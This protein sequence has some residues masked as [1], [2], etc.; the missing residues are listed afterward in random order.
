MILQSGTVGKR[1]LESVDWSPNGIVAFSVRGGEARSEERRASDLALRS[2]E[3][4]RAT[5]LKLA[6]SLPLDAPLRETFLSATRH[7]DLAARREHLPSQLGTQ[8]KPR[9]II[10]WV[11]WWEWRFTCWLRLGFGSRIGLVGFGWDGYGPTPFPFVTSA[12]LT[13]SSI[14]RPCARQI[15]S[16]LFKFHTQGMTPGGTQSQKQNK[17]CE[18]KK[19]DRSERCVHAGPPSSKKRD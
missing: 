16:R 18:E 17:P 15:F 3:L 1:F 14:A 9:I 13:Y 8:F 4:S 10:N 19:R 6:N 5:V 2:R 12:F 7:T 11:S